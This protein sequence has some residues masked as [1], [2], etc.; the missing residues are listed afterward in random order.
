LKQVVNEA[1]SIA[2]TLK[3]AKF[4]DENE[5]HRKTHPKPC[6]ARPNEKNYKTTTRKGE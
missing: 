2:P 4:V 6:C 1:C 3:L 5:Q